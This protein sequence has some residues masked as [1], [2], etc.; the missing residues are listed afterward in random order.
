ML[1]TASTQVPDSVSQSQWGGKPTLQ[2]CT[3]MGR[4]IHTQ[5]Q[6]KQRKREW[7]QD[8]SAPGRRPATTASEIA[9]PLDDRMLIHSVCRRLAFVR[10]IVP[11]SLS[12][13][14]HA[15]HQPRTSTSQIAS[16]IVIFVLACS[17]STMC[18]NYLLPLS[19]MYSR[20][21]SMR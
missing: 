12:P 6:T 18:A 16:G 8:H 4:Q 10:G 20:T 2:Y 17:L 21:T 11:H 1:L 7:S 3:R 19:I 15:P 14:I 13:R 5:V 9:N